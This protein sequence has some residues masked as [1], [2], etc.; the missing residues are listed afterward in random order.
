MGAYGIAMELASGDL[1]DVMYG[2]ELSEEQVGLFAAGIVLGVYD[3][4][5]L[6]VVH[7]DL[8]PG[9]VLVVPGQGKNTL[10]VAKIGDLGSACCLQ[11]GRASLL[12]ERHH[13]RSPW[14]CAAAI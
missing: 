1:A 13:A 11:P 2:Q 10:S 4:H 7:C 5:K 12:H 14:C 3:M 6:G 9:N 8:K